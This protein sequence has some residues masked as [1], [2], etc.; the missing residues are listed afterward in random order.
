MSSAYVEETFGIL[1]DD[2]LYLDCLL[3]RPVNTDDANLKALRVWVPKY[4]LT[5]SSVI[6]CARQEVQSAGPDGKIAHLV[7]DLR[8]T[9]DSD[10][11]PG[12]LNF[13]MDLYGVAAWAKERFGRINFGFLGTPTL[14]NGRVYMWPL[15]A[16]AI[17]ESYYYPPAGT[18]TMPNTVLYLATYGNFGVNDDALCHA[19]AESGYA[20]YGLDPLRYLLHASLKRPL[21]PEDLAEDL[22]ML[23]QMLPSKPIVIAQPLAAGLAV[24]WASLQEEIRGLIAIGRAQIGLRPSHIFA[25]PNPYTYLLSRY[26]PKISPRP[27]ALV[28]LKG[29]PQGGDDDE[30]ANLYQNSKDP[31]RIERVEKLSPQ[32]LLNLLAWIQEDRT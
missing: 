7:F 31:H 17:M 9:G 3:V 15:R 12:D 27:L 10:G 4:P 21:T 22:R 16:G 23:V 25:N 5:K 2:N 20:V 28:I 26:T 29:H 13:Q 14:E 19:L 32:F 1:T 30:M 8:G 24:M 11:P 18:K 6:T